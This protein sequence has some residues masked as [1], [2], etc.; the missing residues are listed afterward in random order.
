MGSATLDHFA[1]PVAGALLL[2][3]K[4]SCDLQ[5]LE[6]SVLLCGWHV[7]ANHMLLKGVKVDVA[8]RHGS[9]CLQWPGGYLAHG[10]G[11]IACGLG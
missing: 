10:T 7:R 2:G 11:G 4:P 1:C 3:P 5:V 6:A 8:Q 9:C